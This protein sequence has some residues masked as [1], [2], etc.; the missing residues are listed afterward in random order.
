ME[1]F[2]IKYWQALEKYYTSKLAYANE[3]AV[4]FA[5]FDIDW[6]YDQTGSD[7]ETCFSAVYERASEMY[8]GVSTYDDIW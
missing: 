6:M 1:I 3:V 5:F 2:N 7:F 4:D 8:T